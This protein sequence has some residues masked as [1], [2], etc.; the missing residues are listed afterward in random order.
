MS[1][2]IRPLTSEAHSYG[3]KVGVVSSL[4]ETVARRTPAMGT[5]GTD[6]WNTPVY[7]RLLA[8][9]HEHRYPHYFGAVRTLVLR[10]VQPPHGGMVLIF[11][12]ETPCP[13]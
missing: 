9:C 2:Y 10:E 7:E 8:I 5:R 4:L 1:P 13:E 12:P 11:A 3:W 6:G